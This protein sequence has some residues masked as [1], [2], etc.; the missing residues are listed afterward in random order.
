MDNEII[1]LILHKGYFIMFFIMII[2]GPVITII[3]AFLA[4]LGFFSVLIVLLLSI[5][6]DVIGDLFFYYIGKYFGLDFI[7][8]FGKYF[9]MNY[10]RFRK[11]SELFK[12]HEGKVIFTSKATTGLGVITFIAAGIVR[13]D[14]TKFLKF[15]IFGGIIWSV[16]LISVG[17]F[18]GY[19]YEEISAYISWSKWVLIVVLIIFITVFRFLKKKK[20]SILE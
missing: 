7:D 14:I 12:K 11:V 2:E 5:L 4:S 9:G 10:K 15:S 20:K 19:L 8:K 16:F 17:Y 3:S 1:Q 18:F 6:G 13:M